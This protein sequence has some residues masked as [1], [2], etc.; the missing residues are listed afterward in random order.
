MFQ[1]FGKKSRPESKEYVMKE[2][3][4]DFHLIFYYLSEKKINFLII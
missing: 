2:T 4:I 1:F 3:L